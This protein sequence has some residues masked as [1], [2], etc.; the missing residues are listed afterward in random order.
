MLII[1]PP[2]ETASFLSVINRIKNEAQ[3]VQS[4]FLSNATNN[5]SRTLA[6]QHAQNAIAILNQIWT[7][8]IAKK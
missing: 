4:N 3:L 7:K 2:D 6:Q 1:L 5:S 8:E